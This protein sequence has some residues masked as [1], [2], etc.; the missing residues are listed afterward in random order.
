M[1]YGAFVMLSKD[2]TADAVKLI[3]AVF[4]IILFLK[5]V[6]NII[7]MVLFVMQSIIAHC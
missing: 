6:C 4:C 2:K 3:V 5:H 7:K 1:A